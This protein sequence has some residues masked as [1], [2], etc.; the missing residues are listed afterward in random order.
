MGLKPTLFSTLSSVSGRDG[1]V[2]SFTSLSACLSSLHL[3]A[4]QVSSS[5]RGDME[6]VSQ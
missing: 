3:L 5:F 6:I 2:T 1:S 4:P